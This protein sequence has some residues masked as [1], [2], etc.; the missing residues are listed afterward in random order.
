MQEKEV[1]ETETHTERTETPVPEA[2]SDTSRADTGGP[3]GTERSLNENVTG[4]Q[5]G[6]SGPTAGR[7]GG[8]G[9]RGR[10]FG[11]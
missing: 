6:T 7:E 2:G 8:G 9:S 4:E 11:N 3:T 1:R 5:A 10:G